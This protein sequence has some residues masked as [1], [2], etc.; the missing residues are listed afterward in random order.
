M[1]QETDD[2]TSSQQYEYRK[3]PAVDALLR[4]PETALLAA[5]YGQTQVAESIRG[6][7]AQARASIAAGAQA[8]TPQSWPRLISEQL[9]DSQR[10]TLRPV[11]NATGVIIHTNLG[12]APLSH[13]AQAAIQGVVAGYSNLEY[14][15]ETGGRGSRYDHTRALLCE[16]TGAEDA[17]V[18]NNNAAAVYL[19]LA[20]LCRD[21]EVLIS[22]GQLVE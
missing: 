3:L 11:I 16:L 5:E 9:L 1:T 18:V 2:S 20:A 6:L 4:L 17:L 10:P 15:L 22:R 8:P 14:D 21:R 7:M 12:R 13:H 19:A